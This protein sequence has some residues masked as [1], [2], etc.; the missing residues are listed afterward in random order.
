MERISSKKFFH[1]T[2]GLYSFLKFDRNSIGQDY[3]VVVVFF[4][5]SK[6]CNDEFLFFPLYILVLLRCGL[7]R[8]ES[9]ELTKS[10]SVQGQHEALGKG[11][12]PTCLKNPSASNRNAKLSNRKVPRLALSSSESSVVNIQYLTSLEAFKRSLFL[13]AFTHSIRSHDFLIIFL[14]G[15]NNSDSL[16]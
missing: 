8:S 2:L 9:A 4:F 16:L 7:R 5:N 14:V 15:S 6:F 13:K 10:V 11:S 1:F 3:R 12:A